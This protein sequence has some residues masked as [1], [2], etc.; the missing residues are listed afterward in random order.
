MDKRKRQWYT[1]V[2]IVATAILFFIAGA[3]VSDVY[4]PR[5]LAN[6]EVVYV[7]QTTTTTM[8]TTSD[9]QNA[10]A[11]SKTTTTAAYQN[12]DTTTT[13]TILDISRRKIPLNSATK[14]ELMMVPGIGET[15]AQRILDYR[16]AHGPFT[17]LEQLKNIA[18]IGEKRYEQW[19]PYFSLD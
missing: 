14:E 7:P 13:T 18:G 12:N 8:S 19:A 16:N 2:L 3:L 15:F 6:T 5:S 11:I 10:A 17:D 1:G 4:G 9:T